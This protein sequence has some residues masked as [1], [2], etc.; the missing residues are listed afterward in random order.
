MRHDAQFN[1]RIIRRDQLTAFR[2]DEGLADAPTFL[3]PHRDVLQIG[4]GRGQAPGRRDGLMIRRVDPPSFGVNLFRQLVGIGGFQ[5]A[6]GPMIEDQAGQ[7]IHFRQILQHRLVSGRLPRR[8]F[9]NDRQIQFV[10]KNCLNL[11]RR[12][13]I[14]R[15]TGSGM[16]FFFNFFHALRQFPALPCQHEHIH[17]HAGALHPR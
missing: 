1:L 6:H 13:Q 7:V 15:L 10:V 9:L 2:G 5:L 11:L 12:A 14:E 16:G 17:Q 4:V 8:R 3:S